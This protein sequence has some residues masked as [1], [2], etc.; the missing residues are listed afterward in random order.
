MSKFITDKEHSRTASIFC[1]HFKKIPAEPYRSLPETYG[2]HAPT[3][4]TCERWFRR[5]KSDDFQVADKEHEE[6]SQ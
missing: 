4:E 3:Q 1:F 2:E 5:L 6:N